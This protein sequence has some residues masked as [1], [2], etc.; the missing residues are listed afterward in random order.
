[1]LVSDVLP[2][3]DS[4]HAFHQSVHAVINRADMDKLMLIIQQVTND[5]AIFLSVYRDVQTRI[6]QGKR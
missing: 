1:M 6:F 5:N 2:S 4:M 3:L